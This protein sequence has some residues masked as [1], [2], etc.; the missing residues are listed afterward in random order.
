M[1]LWQRRTRLSFGEANGDVQDFGSFD[2]PAGCNGY[3]PSAHYLSDLWHEHMSS[4]PVALL[5]D[6]VKGTEGEVRVVR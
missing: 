6:I 5:D 4:R 3:V 2:D 1:V